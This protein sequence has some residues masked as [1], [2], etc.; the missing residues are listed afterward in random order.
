MQD[1]FLT[2]SIVCAENTLFMRFSGNAGGRKGRRAAPGANVK[3]NDT[4][5]NDDRGT[6]GG[7]ETRK[8]LSGAVFRRFCAEKA[9]TG[10][11]DA[12]TIKNECETIRET[13]VAAWR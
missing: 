8:R 3:K 5:I 13:E 6:A 1:F 2:G 11:K 12:V 7:S 4:R 9:L 10:P